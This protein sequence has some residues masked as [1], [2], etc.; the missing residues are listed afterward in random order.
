[1]KIEFANDNKC[2]KHDFYVDPHTIEPL[3]NNTIIEPIEQT[4]H[5]SPNPG[6]NCMCTIS[7]NGHYVTDLMLVTTVSLTNEVCPI[8]E[9]NP[10]DKVTLDFGGQED[11]NVAMTEY[12]YVDNKNVVFINRIHLEIDGVK[13]YINFDTLVP[14]F[15]EMK[16]ICKFKTEEEFGCPYSIN[17]SNVI[18]FYMIERI[19]LMLTSCCEFKHGHA[20]S[21]MDSGIVNGSGAIMVLKNDHHDHEMRISECSYLEFSFVDMRGLDFDILSHIDYLLLQIGGYDMISSYAC[22]TYIYMADYFWSQYRDDDRPAN[23]FIVPFKA[24]GGHGYD[25]LPCNLKIR[26]RFSDN[27]SCQFQVDVHH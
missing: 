7:R 11:N 9:S 1:M 16:M 25:L 27:I 15:H 14:K 6:R 18:P 19:P 5:G 3:F 22:Q 8:S 17:Q 24:L 21:V 10:V 20:L 26:L 12:S 13:K 2:S 23:K 4:F